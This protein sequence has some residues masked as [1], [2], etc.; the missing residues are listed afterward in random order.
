LDNIE[1]IVLIGSKIQSNYIE[2]YIELNS[3]EYPKFTREIKYGSF[4]N[5]LSKNENLKVIIA[6]SEDKLIG[7]LMISFAERQGLY[8]FNMLV[9]RD[10]QRK[11]IGSKLLLNAKQHYNELYGVVVPVNRYKRR[12]GTQYHSPLEFYKQNGFTLTGKK[13]VEYRDVT[14]LE[15][16]W[17]N[18]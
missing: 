2:Q 10:F 1:F 8:H 4:K 14:M 3:S 5:F 17:T 13:F 6:T 12:D 15:I 9:H 18:K 11:G 7:W 16:K